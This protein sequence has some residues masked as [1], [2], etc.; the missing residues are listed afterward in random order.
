M[1]RG[2]GQS[3]TS[4]HATDKTFSAQQKIMT[5]EENNAISS[6]DE[7]NSKIFQL[8]KSMR[9]GAKPGVSTGSIVKHDPT[10]SIPDH[11]I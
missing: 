9:K 8:T 2:Y 3:I 7:E 10:L 5:G 11:T 1:R 4:F 6:S